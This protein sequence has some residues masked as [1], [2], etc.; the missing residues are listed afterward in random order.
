VTDD[1]SGEQTAIGRRRRPT[2]RDIAAAAKVS[3]TLVGMILS[4]APG[5][6]PATAERV[7]AVADHLGYRADRAAAA[8]ARHRTRLIG[9]TSIPSNVFHGELVEEIQALAA[10]E[11]YEVV[12]GSIMDGQDECQAIETL[13]GFRCEAV[14]ILGPSTAPEK[15][16]LLAEDTTLV[17]VGSL[18]DV[19]TID[20]VRAD[21][22]AGIQQLVDHLVSLGHRQIV[23][24][25]G[26]RTGGNAANIRREAYLAA[27]RR[28]GLPVEVI[29][30]GMTESAGTTAAAQLDLSAVTAVMCFND[31]S[32][33][34]VLD[35][36]D[37]AGVRVPEH[38]SITGY[39]DSFIARLQRI[40]LTSV[41][42]SPTIQARLALDMVIDR[43]DR[44]RTTPRRTLLPAKVVLRRSTG[45]VRSETPS[46]TPV[47]NQTC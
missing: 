36:L 44:G 21:D 28:H 41:N 10:S 22:D 4:G 3:K 34:G 42:Q 18:I 29:P 39:D 15:L 43:L 31:R 19:P 6:S 25:E 23:H 8:L 46:F 9:I 5:P 11:G 45:P 26:A 33:V 47:P 2:I 32:A 7:F 24:I 35:F 17:A 27:M 40:S 37:A 12:L 14:L 30:G 1:G 13:I 16:R 38:V 20:V